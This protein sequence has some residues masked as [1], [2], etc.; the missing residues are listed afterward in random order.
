M[1][2][3][4][5]AVFPAVCLLWAIL[6]LPLSA[7]TPHYLVG[8]PI[9]D[10]TGVMHRIVQVNDVSVLTADGLVIL[11]TTEVGAVLPDPNDPAKTVTIKSVRNNATTN[12]PEVLTFEELGSD[13]VT[14]KAARVST[15][16]SGVIPSFGSNTG[17][18]G[19]GTATASVVTAGD[20]NV[21][22]DIRTGA[23]G[24]D[25]GNGFTLRTC[26]WFFGDQCVTLG[27]PATPGGPGQAAPNINDT[28]GTPNI[29]TV[30]D[31][32]PGIVVAGVGGGGEYGWL[33]YLRRHLHHCGGAAAAVGVGGGGGAGGGA[34][35]TGAQI[36]SR[37]TTEGKNAGAV[38]VRSVGGGGGDGGFNASGAIASSTPGASSLAVGT[39]GAGGSGGA[40]GIGARDDGRRCRDVRCR[41]ARGADR[42]RRGRRRTR[43]T[44]PHGSDQSVAGSGECFFDRGWRVGWGRW[45]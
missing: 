31:G 39:G 17:P 40:G 43:R 22:H 2:A 7:E 20:S 11:T 16:I 29:Q 25:G 45:R 8:D 24:A 42:E 1:I 28:V 18:G 9:A 21:F 6:A 38:A 12:R 10:P 41:V 37:V 13:G 35:D 3:K 15:D 30:S 33:Q 44:E 34:G 19:L 27:L 36:S 32:V 4:R 14:V 23:S 26:F 5:P